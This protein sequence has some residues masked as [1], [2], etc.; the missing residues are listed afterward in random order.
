MRERFDYCF[1]VHVLEQNV[2]EA[3][4]SVRELFNSRLRYRDSIVPSSCLI[5]ERRLNV[6]YNPVDIG[7]KGIFKSF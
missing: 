2:V 1:N 7:F 6:E 3:V 4:T 5:F